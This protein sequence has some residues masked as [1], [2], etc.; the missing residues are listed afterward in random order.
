L[1]EAIL[2]AKRRDCERF[3]LWGVAP[4]DETRHRFASLSVFKRGFGGEEV[5][6]LPAHDLPLTP[7]Y[8]AIRIF[9]IFRKRLRRV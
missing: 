9:E 4:K 7:R 5:E 1:W 6:Y 3:N 8:K 2:E